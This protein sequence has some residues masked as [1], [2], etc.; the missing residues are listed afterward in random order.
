M[1]DWVYLRLHPYQHVR[2][3]V[4]KSF[5]LSP[6]YFGPFQILKKIGMV[7]YELDLPTNS[8]IYPILHVSYL[9]KKIGDWVNPNPRLPMVMK[10]GTLTPEPE[11]IIERRIEQKGSRAG[12]ELLVQWR[13][14]TG[15]TPRGWMSRNWGKLIQSS[16]A[17][18]SEGGD[19]VTS[20]PLSTYIYGGQCAG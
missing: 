8:K 9:K 2:V 14:A 7:A 16:W 19:C 4:R 20:Q 18:S 1:E 12:V 11:L 3:I 6:R 10:N 5:K 17:S 13:G 15:R